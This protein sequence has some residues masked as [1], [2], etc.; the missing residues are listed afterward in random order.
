[1]MVLNTD[2]HSGTVGKK[3]QMT[4]DVFVDHLA[5]LNDGRDFHPDLL[6]DI[7]RSIKEKPFVF[8]A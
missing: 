8:Q 6:G 4:L 5:G 1:M 2:L 3:R 7:Y